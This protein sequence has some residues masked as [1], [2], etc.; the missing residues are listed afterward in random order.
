MTLLAKE[1]LGLFNKINHKKSIQMILPILKS[2]AILN[3][4]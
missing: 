1:S 3:S 2:A 4:H